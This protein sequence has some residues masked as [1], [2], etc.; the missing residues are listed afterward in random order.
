MNEKPDRLLGIVVL[1]VTAL[2]V[3]GMAWCV[4]V[5]L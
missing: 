3:A 5:K 2:M 1:V 4:V